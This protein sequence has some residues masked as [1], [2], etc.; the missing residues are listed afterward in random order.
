MKKLLSLFIVT[1][2]VF[3]MA[4]TPALAGDAGDRLADG[5]KQ[6]AMSPKNVPD[7]LVE[8]YEAA[9]F[10]PFGLIGGLLKGVSM[11]VIDLSLGLGKVVTFPLDLTGQ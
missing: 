7:S 6:F 10:K 2:F 11:T 4:A 3:I 1:A 5:F 8:E 9:D